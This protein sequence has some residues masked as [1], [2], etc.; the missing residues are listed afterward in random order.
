MPKEFAFEMAA[1]SIRFGAGATTEC[2]A[3]LAEIGARNV[4]VFTD[5]AL[6]QLPPVAIALA[7][8]ES[9]GVEAHVFDRVRVKHSVRC[10]AR[11]RRR[12]DGRHGKDR[13]SI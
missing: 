5:P 2:G 4:L 1:S 12:L 8:L 9:N 10:S 6:A 11:G 13:Q 3:D 7:S